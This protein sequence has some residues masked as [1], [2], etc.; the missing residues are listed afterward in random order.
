[1]GGSEEGGC[2]AAGA[3]GHTRAFNKH[4]LTTVFLPAAWMS[5][6]SAPGRTD[7]REG[8]VMHDGVGGGGCADY[9]FRERAQSDR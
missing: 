5:W 4:R 2:S 7:T 8:R 9:P 1:M 3:Q 6:C